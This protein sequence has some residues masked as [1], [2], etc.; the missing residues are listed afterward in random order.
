MLFDVANGSTN[1]RRELKDCLF[2]ER[3]ELLDVDTLFGHIFYRLVDVSDVPF[4]VNNGATD[5]D[6]YLLEQS[7]PDCQ[8]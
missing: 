7:V 8:V 2:F 6:E 1:D 4:D 5:V 3:P